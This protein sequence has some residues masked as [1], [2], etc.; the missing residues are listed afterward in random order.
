MLSYVVLTGYVGQ[1][2]LAQM[3]L[4]GVAAFFMARMMANGLTSTVNPFPVSGPG[5]HWLIAMVLGILMAIVV[6]LIVAIPALR[7]RGVQLA[8][9]TI[10]G[11]D[12][13]AVPLLRE[14]Q[15][16]P[17][18]G[19]ARRRRSPG[20][21]SSASTSARRVPRASPN[22]PPFIIFCLVML[23]GSCWLVA[24]IRRSGTGR[25]F[26]SVR[27][28]ERAAAAAGVNV[29]RTKMLAFGIGAGLAGLAG[30]LFAFQARATSR[31]PASSSRSG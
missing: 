21:R 1:I 7:I 3:A 6:G 27:A 24:N 19:P 17:A 8:V 23:V 25:R 9:V 14:R 30:M 4:A 18:C 26:L 13:A 28:N 29:P 20:R 22:N 15:A 11:G 2:S 5:L 31:R 10:A 12:H 16:R